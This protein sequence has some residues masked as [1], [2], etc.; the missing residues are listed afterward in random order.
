MSDPTYTLTLTLSQ[1]DTLTV[2]E[3]GTEAIPAPLRDIVALGVL[4]RAQILILSPYED[5]TRETTT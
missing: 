5:V 3:A 1:D 2:A 4:S